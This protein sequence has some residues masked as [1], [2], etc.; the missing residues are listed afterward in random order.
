MPA[1]HRS[2]SFLDLSWGTTLR[3]TRYCTF[4]RGCC[5]YPKE[6]STGR[7]ASPFG[8]YVYLPNFRACRRAVRG[9]L[10]G[11]KSFFGAH[12]EAEYKAR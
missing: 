10:S 6:R 3:E 4:S 9:H 5:R 8:F 7:G 2:Y 12:H 11:S 1:P